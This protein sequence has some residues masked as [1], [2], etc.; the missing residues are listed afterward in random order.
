VKKYASLFF[1][2]LFS[3]F[4]VSACTFPFQK[5]KLEPF[6]KGMLV[7]ANY[8]NDQAKL[9]FSIPIGWDAKLAEDA[10]EQL[11][12]TVKKAGVD[13]D[14][15]SPSTMDFMCNNP[16]TGSNM[17]I[18]YEP[19]KNGKDFD[20]NVDDLID[21]GMKV[22]KSIGIDYSKNDSFNETIAGHDCR[23][24]V[25]DM[26]YSGVDMVEYACF[27]EVDSYMCMIIVVPSNF[28]DHDETFEAIIGNFSEIEE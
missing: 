3:L 17:S 10:Q 1:L 28:I 5:A 4:L 26:T 19:M 11:S 21:E 12:D 27:F 9:K 23:V 15:Y 2:V 14:D 25:L 8:F 22:G 13:T 24:E 6:E 18:S 20:E 7:G 16:N